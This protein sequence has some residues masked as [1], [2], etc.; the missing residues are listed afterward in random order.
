MIKDVII[1]QLKTA[2]QALGLSIYV[3]GMNEFRNVLLVF[4]RVPLYLAV[5]KVFAGE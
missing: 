5:F 1:Q 3:R 2:Q 4:G